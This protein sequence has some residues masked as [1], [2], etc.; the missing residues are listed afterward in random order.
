MA[1]TPTWLVHSKD[2]TTVPYEQS[3]LWAFNLLQP[4]GNVL[5]TAYDH[6]VWNGYQFNGHFSWV[7]TARND[8][9]THKGRTVWEWMDR[10][11]LRQKHMKK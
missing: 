1:R 2:D 10:Q 6:V 5:L 9:T 3:S 11:N 8:P 4:Y 7:Y